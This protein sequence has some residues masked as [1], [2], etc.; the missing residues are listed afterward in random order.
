MDCFSYFS[1][2]F[3]TDGDGQH[4]P[5][6]SFESPQSLSP[7][8]MKQAL[9]AMMI[10]KDE[11]ENNNRLVDRWVGMCVTSQIHDMFFVNHNI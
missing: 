9:V 7:S 4:S 5:V 1:S 6:P 2:T 8:E 11:V 10:R 3:R